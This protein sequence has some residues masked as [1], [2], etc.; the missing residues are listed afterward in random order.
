MNIVIKWFVSKKEDPNSVKIWEFSTD[1]FNH[2]TPKVGD[3]LSLDLP[4]S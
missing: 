4:I 2:E 1:N 3:F